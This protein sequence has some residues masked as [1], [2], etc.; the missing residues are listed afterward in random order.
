MQCHAHRPL[1][2][3]EF[4]RRVLDRRAV[5]RDRLQYV[6]LPRRQR[7]QLR[8][9]FARWRGGRGRLARDRFGEIV[10]I[11]ENPPAPAA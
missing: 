11:D 6:A 3:R 9:D 8:G 5:D 2:H 4:R 10:D 1:T 7:L